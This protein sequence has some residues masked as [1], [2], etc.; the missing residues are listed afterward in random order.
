MIAN[1]DREHGLFSPEVASVLEATPDGVVVV[2]ADSTVLFVSEFA[3]EMFNWTVPELLGQ[4]VS[5]LLPDRLATVHHDHVVSYFAK[6]R[7]RRM[8]EA[9]AALV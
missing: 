9:A 6:P 2:D 1:S 8:G 4:Q 5:I 3:A 7:R